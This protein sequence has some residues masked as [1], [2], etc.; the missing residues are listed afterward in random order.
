MSTNVTFNPILGKPSE[1]AAVQIFDPPMCCSSG[2]CGPTQD[3]ALVDANE[4][5]LSLAARGVQVERY[6]MTTNPGAFLGNGE[7]MRLIRLR[8]NM[9]ALPIT[10]VNGHVIKTDAYPNLREIESALEGRRG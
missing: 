2:L 5:L 10:V 3:Q 1:T 6:Q 7:V 8:Q 4:M 9:S